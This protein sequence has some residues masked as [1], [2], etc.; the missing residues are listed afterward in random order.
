MKTTKYLSMLLMALAMTVCMIGCGDDEDNYNENSI[1]G[2]W[3]TQDGSQ[4]H[5][6]KSDGT[7]TITDKAG[8]RNFQYTCVF[9]EGK[10]SLKRWFVDNEYIYNYSVQITGNTLMLTYGSETLILKRK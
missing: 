8:V 5:V 1:V 7:G 10:G 6:F 9:T 4:T 3:I 2:T